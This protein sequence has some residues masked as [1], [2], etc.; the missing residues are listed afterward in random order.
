MERRAGLSPALTAAAERLEE[1]VRLRG[2]AASG[3]AF[4]AALQVTS[5]LP[6]GKESLRGTIS[7]GIPPLDAV[8]PGGGFRRGTLVEWLDARQ[9][10]GAGLL[11][12][13]G[14]RQA[15]RL[16]GMLVVLDGEREFYPPA[17]LGQGIE[18]ARLVVLRIREPADAIWALEQALR[19]AG[20]AGVIARIA[21]LPDRSFRRLQLAAEAGGSLGFLIRPPQAWWTPSWAEIRFWV[22]S[23]GK[24]PPLVP[25]GTI[26]QN[27][28]TGGTG[29]LLTDVPPSPIK[30]EDEVARVPYNTGPA[31]RATPCESWGEIVT[32][33]RSIRVEVL[34]CPKGKAGAVLEIEC[35]EQTGDVRLATP[36]VHPASARHPDGVL[37]KSRSAV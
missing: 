23:G 2:E 37:R 4:Q 21:R 34:R 11:A 10:A 1:I 25:Q 8:L 7:S 18:L 14:A 12:L 15:L 13:Q 9:G 33:N 32:R 16:G 6:G 27:P 24:R 3:D 26:S 29:G 28:S 22:G 17:A 30:P 20:V 31:A 19:C 35:D 36:L 5:R